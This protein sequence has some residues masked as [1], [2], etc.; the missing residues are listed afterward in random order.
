MQAR[1]QQLPFPSSSRYKLPL[2]FH[3]AALS[4]ISHQS[5]AFKLL[6][7]ST[8]YLTW[9]V[10]YHVA[11]CGRPPSP[12]NPD[13]KKHVP[14]GAAPRV[15]RPSHTV[16]S[17]IINL[18]V[19]FP[20]TSPKSKAGKDAFHLARSLT[21]LSVHRSS[22]APSDSGNCKRQHRQGHQ[23][24]WE[25]GCR[26]WASSGRS[27]LTSTPLQ[28][29]FTTSDHQSLT[30]SYFLFSYCIVLFLSF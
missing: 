27:S 3:L 26:R 14:N 21:H 23:V 20:G 2:P 25:E 15:L 16:A 10:L 24:S 17:Y 18:S 6:P 28:G 7:D 19:P 1:M 30:I 8:E 5:K 22:S 4:W 11:T 29:M 9:T 13:K 12:S